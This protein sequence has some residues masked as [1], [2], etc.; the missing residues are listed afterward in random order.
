[1][2][3]ILL[4]SISLLFISC[5][6]QLEEKA[7]YYDDGKI[8]ILEYYKG[9]S[10]M[11][12]YYFNKK[13]DTIRWVK[14]INKYK[15]T[16]K[17]SEGFEAE[18]QYAYR[19]MHVVD[20]YLDFRYFNDKDQI[21]K[22]YFHTNNQ[23]VTLVLSYDSLGKIW[24]FQEYIDRDSETFAFGLNVVLNSEGD[25]NPSESG[26]IAKYDY[27]VSY[28][29]DSTY[30]DIDFKIP[31]EESVA[32]DFKKIPHSS[33]PWYY[34]TATYVESR[35]VFKDLFKYSYVTSGKHCDLEIGGM[36]HDKL[37]PYNVGDTLK[38]LHFPVFYDIPDSLGL[39]KQLLEILDRKIIYE[40][41]D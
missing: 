13:G 25:I 34:D 7:S 20:G 23:D 41:C 5:S 40:Y 26:L 11:L 22:R 35:N 21:Q 6:N 12:A 29:N 28:Q 31:Y 14:H 18:E 36:I 2:K 16:E 24:Y 38:S 3:Y 8:K 19:I 1:M 15:W 27:K 33:K 4:L 30:I 37:P 32:I 9:D 10:L 39:P 17:I